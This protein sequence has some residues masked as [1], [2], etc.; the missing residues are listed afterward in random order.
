MLEETGRTHAEGSESG[1]KDG[2]KQWRFGIYI[3]GRSNGLNNL[4]DD[5]TAM[6][7]VSLLLL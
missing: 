7:N 4:S 5:P 1:T 6:N 3:L 2:T